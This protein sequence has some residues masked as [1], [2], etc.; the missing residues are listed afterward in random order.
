MNTPIAVT[1]WSRYWLRIGGSGPEGLGGLE[2][3]GSPG[4]DKY[5]SSYDE[6]QK[7]LADLSKREFQQLRHL[8]GKD[9][10]PEQLI[11]LLNRVNEE[12]LKIR[13]PIAVSLSSYGSSEAEA[14]IMM[15]I[16]CLRAWQQVCQE[17]PYQWFVRL[18]AWVE[19]RYPYVLQ[20]AWF[21]DRC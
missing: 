21:S 16:Y 4:A 10:K 6:L 15:D 12:W 19:Y 7:A 1:S 8:F 11:S 3:L 9:L 13:Q 14:R 18:D 5:A 17:E 2:I 20:T